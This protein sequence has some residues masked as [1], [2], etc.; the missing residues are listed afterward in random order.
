MKNA[1]KRVFLLVFTL[2]S[3]SFNPPAELGEGVLSVVV[4]GI[5]ASSGTVRVV[6]YNSNNKFLERDGYVYKQVIEVGNKKS[7]KLDFKIPHG[8]YSVSADSFQ[9][10][11]LLLLPTYCNSSRTFFGSEAFTSS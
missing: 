4:N 2:F 3:L 11:L 10:R 7:V 6:I 9:C 8:Y 1:L 5:A